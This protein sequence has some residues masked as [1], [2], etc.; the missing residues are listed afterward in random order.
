MLEVH[1]SEPGIPPGLKPILCGEV[2]VG[3][4]QA[5]IRLVVMSRPVG[6]WLDFIDLVEGKFHAS[7]EVASSY[8][9]GKGR[10]PIRNAQK[11]SSVIIKSHCPEPTVSV[12]QLVASVVVRKSQVSLKQ[13]GQSSY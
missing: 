6:L 5:F 12:L 9:Y 1:L 2:A 13:P 10:R 7:M 3:L 4:G 11:G 8:L